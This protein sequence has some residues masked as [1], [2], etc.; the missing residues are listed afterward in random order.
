MQVLVLGGAG[1]IGRAAVWDLAMQAAITR[2]V[3]GDLNSGA[4]YALRS[5]V[6]HPKLAVAQID[7]TDPAAL[8]G[9]LRGMNAC[10]N[11]TQYYHNLSVMRACLEAGV[12]YVDLG[13]LYHMTRRQLELDG[14]FRRAGLLAIPG[15]GVCPGVT[16]VQAR[17]AADGLDSVAA[18]RMYDGS[19][20]SEDSLQWSYSI[21]T[22]LDEVSQKPVT[23]REGEYIELEPLSEPES[24]DFDVP[25]G[26]KKVHHT[27]HSEI[28]TLPETYRDKGVRDVSFKIDYFGY[29]ERAASQLALLAG[30]G[31]AGREP[32]AV[33][34]GAVRPRDL[35]VELLKRQP[36]YA[37]HSALDTYEQVVTTVEGTRDGRPIRIRVGTMGA[38][39]WGLPAG[40]VLT[41]VP[42]A[43]A[44]GWLAEGTLGGRGVIPPERAL[45]P[46]PFLEE[47]DKR[48]CKTHMDT[49]ELE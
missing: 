8:A 13:G 32:V 46:E 42:A 9:A 25:I 3:I 48:G 24:F 39:R 22:I 1:L 20:P 6:G 29:T 17:L 37:T 30:L 18:I 35:L 15:V 7:V 40:S 26:R 41:G 23:F 27:L 4:A 19:H 38:P 14:E 33:R 36:P 11:A 49:V 28:A 2:V 43:I 44:A 31:L 16:N 47:L 10:L 45:A 34:D 12:P 21:D 5:Q